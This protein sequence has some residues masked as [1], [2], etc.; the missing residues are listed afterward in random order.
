MWAAALWSPARLLLLKPL[1]PLGQIL[2]ANVDR[3]IAKGFTLLRGQQD[4]DK[5]L[6]RLADRRC[7]QWPLLV[8]GQIINFGEELPERDLIEREAVGSSVRT[9][10]KCTEAIDTERGFACC[11]TDGADHRPQQ[12]LACP[13]GSDHHRPGLARGDNGFGQLRHGHGVVCGPGDFAE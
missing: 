7:R 11:E 2:P 6:Q 5:P 9:K 13:V 10:R 1:Q 4:R 8:A 3:A 12:R